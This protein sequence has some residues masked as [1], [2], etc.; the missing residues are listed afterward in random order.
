MRRAALFTTNFVPYSQTFIYDEVISH[1]RYEVD[2]FAQNRKNADSFPYERVFTPPN[3]I[4]KFFH[5]NR[6]YWPG[7][8]SYFREH[9]YNVMHSH[10]GFGSVYAIKYK[11]KFNL[12][13]VTTFHGNDVSVLIGKQRYYPKQ[14]RYVRRSKEIFGHADKLLA[15]SIEMK[16][17]L[18]EI[19]G[20]REEDVVLYRLGVDLD[21]FRPSESK[22]NKRTE[23]CFVGRFTEKKG[24][25]YVLKALRKVMEQGFDF[26]ITFVGE[27]SL[28]PRCKLF[29][30]EHNMEDHVHFAGV[31]SHQEVADRLAHSDFTLVPSVVA[32]DHDREGSPMVVKE[33]SAS[34]V[35]VIGT[36]HAGISE[37]IEDEKTGFLVPE[38]HVDAL[39]DR[40]I[41]LIENP[42]LAKEMGKNARQKMEEEF[43]LKNQVAYL[44][45]IYDSVAR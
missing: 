6:A 23:I 4:A 25:I 8:N 17:L 26:N 18:E 39:A 15:V 10:F 11:K 12:P 44:E 14:W 38:R 22:E 33:S 13:W 34:G 32:H 29:V 42:S 24:H 40:I 19:S 2:V 7:F 30:K 9:S 1:E 27:G 5:K 20:R 37:T 35:P 21:R 3:A 28:K 45:E 43:D 36:Y 16:M 31:L 41:T